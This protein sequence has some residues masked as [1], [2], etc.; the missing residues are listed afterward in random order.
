M[1]AALFAPIAVRD[2]MLANR[3]G[4]SSMC[5]YNAEAGSANDWHLMH[6]GQLALGAAGLLMTEATHVCRPADH[7]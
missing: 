6:L 3:I 4:M 1:A 5:Q 2:L 7:A